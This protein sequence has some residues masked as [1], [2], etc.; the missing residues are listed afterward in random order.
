M[1]LKNCLHLLYVGNFT[2]TESELK[3]KIARNGCFVFVCRSKF[4][5][6]KNHMKINVVL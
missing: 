1:G 2:C 4:I 3:T 5:N 6:V